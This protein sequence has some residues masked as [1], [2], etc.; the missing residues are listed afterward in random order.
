LKTGGAE[1]NPGLD[2]LFRLSDSLKPVWGPIFSINS[3][4]GPHY[5]SNSSYLSNFVGPEQRQNSRF[6]ENRGGRD[7]SGFG[8]I[9]STFGLPGTGFVTQ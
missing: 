1:T 5:L 7:K 8:P 3:V 4:S 6:V 9:I 2:P